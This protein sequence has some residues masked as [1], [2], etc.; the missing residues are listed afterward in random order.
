MRIGFLQTSSQARGNQLR[1]GALEKFM[2]ARVDGYHGGASNCEEASHKSTKPRPGIY[3]VVSLASE[4]G[5]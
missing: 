1:S 4:R 2:S 5:T 3:V